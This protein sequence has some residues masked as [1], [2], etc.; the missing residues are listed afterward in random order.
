MRSRTCSNTRAGENKKVCFD[1]NGNWRHVTAATII[2]YSCDIFDG[3]Y[4]DMCGCGREKKGKAMQSRRVD[5][6][7]LSGQS[8]LL[9]YYLYQWE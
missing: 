3:Y 8:V 7:P 2:S 1:K 4:L 6:F 5:E 9:H